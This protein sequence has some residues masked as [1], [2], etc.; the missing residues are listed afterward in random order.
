[1]VAR[2]SSGVAVVVPGAVITVRY[3]FRLLAAAFL[4]LGAAGCAPTSAEMS[5]GPLPNGVSLRFVYPAGTPVPT[6]SSSEAGGR[7]VYTWTRGAV[8]VEV[9]G[10]DL[11]VGG[12]GYGPLAAGD[13]VVIDLRHDTRV[14]VNGTAREP[15]S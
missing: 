7:Y 1:M 4:T 2:H 12:R 13:M 5:V 14:T 10:L 9:R 3:L 6:H 11:T 8:T 15:A